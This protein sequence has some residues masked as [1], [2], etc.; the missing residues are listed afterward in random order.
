MLS[1][2]VFRSIENY[3]LDSDLE[4]V[5]EVGGDGVVHTQRLVGLRI[6]EDK[7]ILSGE[8]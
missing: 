3:L 7:L 4:V 1:S 2:E 6:D 5:L 8:G